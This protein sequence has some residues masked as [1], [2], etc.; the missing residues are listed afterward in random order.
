MELPE[1]DEESEDAF[2]RW[3]SEL[4]DV[5]PLVEA[6]EAAMAERR[7]RLA[8]RLVG[9]V[10]DFVDIEPG[11]AL[12]RARTAARLLLVT[13]VDPQEVFDELESAW[14]DA[15]NRRIWRMKRRMRQR[16]SGSDQRISRWDSRRRR[17]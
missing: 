16:A 11:S 1:R 6:I 15:H 14:R 8:A 17:R 9:F 4:D 10:E 12:D 5:D 3:A 13:P 7:P 2:V